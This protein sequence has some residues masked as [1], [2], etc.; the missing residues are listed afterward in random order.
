MVL[1]FLFADDL[2]VSFTVTYLLNKWNLEYNFNMTTAIL[3][4]RQEKKT[5]LGTCMVNGWRQ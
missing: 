1:A 2:A 5:N 3:F 4:K